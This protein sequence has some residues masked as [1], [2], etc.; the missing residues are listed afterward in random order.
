M[1]DPIKSLPSLPLT[2]SA[3]GLL[4]SLYASTWPHIALIV[5]EVCRLVARV[6]TSA[7]M[8]PSAISASGTGVVVSAG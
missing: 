5:K 4:G 1:I 3:V 2:V 6:T 7:G 8:P